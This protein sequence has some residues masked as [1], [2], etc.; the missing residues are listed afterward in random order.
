MTA[1]AQDS[2]PAGSLRQLLFA[3]RRQWLV[4]AFF[5][6]T[7]CFLY[8]WF[9]TEGNWNLFYNEPF[10]D[11]YDALAHSLWH[12]RMDVPRAAISGEEFKHDGKSYGYFGPAPALPRM[13]LDVIIP[14]MYGRW[15]RISMI[16]GGLVHILLAAA[17]LLRLGCSLK[18]PLAVSLP[19]QN[20]GR[21][22]VGVPYRATVH[23]TMRR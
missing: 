23:P 22:Y 7:G 16:A 17:I 14:P 15:S 21:Q 4:L 8:T 5:L 3:E 18:R 9:T 2:S 1:K 13:I 19:R 11:F 10:T 6:A 20:H 12:G